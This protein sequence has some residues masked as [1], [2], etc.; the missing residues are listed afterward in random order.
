MRCIPLLDTA[1]DQ[2]DWDVDHAAVGSRLRSVEA[3]AGAQ[4]V[5]MVEVVPLF[6]PS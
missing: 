4:D 3:L 1:N 6:S 5:H 2:D